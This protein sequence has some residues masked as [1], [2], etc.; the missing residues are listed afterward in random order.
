MAS[1]TKRKTGGY[2]IEISRGNDRT[3]I[4]LGKCSK[5]SAD[6][7]LNAVN[8]ILSCN[9][10]GVPYSPETAKWTQ[11]IDPKL[12][13]KLSAAGV[14]RHRQRRTFGQFVD[15]YIADK[16]EEWKPNTLRAF[17]QEIKKAVA[18]FGADTPL[19]V[20]TAEQCFKFAAA[21]HKT[22]KSDSNRHR[23]IKRVK[24]VF[25]E[26]VRRELIMK[27]PMAN[28]KAGSQTRNPDSVLFITAETY[29][30]LLDAC[31][32]ARDRLIIGLARYGGLRCPS[33]LAG[34]RW[35][36]IRYDDCQFTVYCVKTERH[37]GKSRRIIPLFPEL[38]PLFQA[39]WETLPDGADDRIFPDFTAE[40]SLG[41]LNGRIQRRAGTDI[42][43]LF[44]NSRFS[45]RKEL[46]R[47]PLYAEFVDEIM[48]HDHETG[49][50][51]Y[52]YVTTQD[53]DRFNT[54]CRQ[55]LIRCAGTSM[56]GRKHRRKRRFC[57]GQK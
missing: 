28:I 33:E 32:S 50:T 14:L 36:E 2:E 34:L 47:D 10:A 29:Q 7:C 25:T 45:R 16:S 27:S 30:R 44:R 55:I 43:E 49:N 9:A 56:R 26:A 5:K 40:K 3:R 12:H 39:L 18:F 21:L 15:E 35:S 4:Y 19:N 51:Y 20:I 37:A 41:S 38:L 22:V 54:M 52:G 53:I 23:S 13:D 24:Q 11:D 57:G 46:K 31:T 17:T 48:G 6:R 8:E 42:P 1:L